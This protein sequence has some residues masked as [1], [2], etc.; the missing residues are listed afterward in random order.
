MTNINK[1]YAYYL[2]DVRD[3]PQPQSL[4]PKIRYLICSSPRTGSTLLGQMLTDTQCAGDPLEYFNPGYFNELQKRSKSNN[5]YKNIEFL[6]KIRTS[7]NGVF[8]LQMHFSHLSQIFKN[9]KTELQNF[10]NSFHKL[11]FIR[12]KNKIKQS[13]SW[14]K[15]STSNE[16]SSIDQDI[17]GH[18]K[19]NCHPQEPVTE[20]IINLLNLITQQDIGWENLLAQKTNATI[21]YYEDLIENWDSEC[22]RIINH[23]IPYEGKIPSMALRKQGLDND[24]TISD[25]NDYLGLKH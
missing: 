20:K 3:F 25:I 2:S 10:I 22:R 4:P 16:Y 11:I 24:K 6:E 12:R 1:K 19:Y 7:S 23:I 13:I 8:G 5:L 17:S 15:A 14:H 9:N 21:I 18:S